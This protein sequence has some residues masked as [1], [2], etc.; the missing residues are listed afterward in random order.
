LLP[1]ERIAPKQPAVQPAD[2]TQPLALRPSLAIPDSLQ[3]LL[4]EKLQSLSGKII[5]LS[6][7]ELD[8]YIANKVYQIL[9]EERRAGRLP[10]APG[11]KAPIEKEGAFSALLKGLGFLTLIF[12]SIS[13]VTLSLIR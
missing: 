11:L 1:P 10:T 12:I 5:V 8:L 3:I 7:E 2:T 13:L 4:L 9:Q 6:K